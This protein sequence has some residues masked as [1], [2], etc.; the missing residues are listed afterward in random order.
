[1]KCGVNVF[2]QSENSFLV[3]A[4]LSENM[5]FERV[6]SMDDKVKC[7]VYGYIA[8]CRLFFPSD[9]P[10]YTISELIIFMILLYYDADELFEINDKKIF[11]YIKKLYGDEY[12]IY[13][14]QRIDRNKVSMYKWI[15][16]T[17]ESFEGRYGI[18]D[19]TEDYKSKIK[20]N[21]TDICYNK[22][23]ANV[24]S[25]KC[26]HDGGC[27]SKRNRKLCSF[28]ER[29]DIVTII[30]DFNENTISFNSKLT[31]ETVTEKLK[32]GIIA[33][34]FIAEFNYVDSVIQ[35]LS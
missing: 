11:N 15:I 23:T 18:I 13:G 19:D 27:F 4:S 2:V 21:E 24:G 29:G 35:I 32:D 20:Q 7:T 1:M 6:K 3:M 14:K 5:R 22:H 30:V 17:S 10:Y 28:I 12:H 9:N 34:R 31:E 16:E 8:Q 25:K 26:G 33:I